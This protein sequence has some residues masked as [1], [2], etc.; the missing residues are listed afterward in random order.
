MKECDYIELYHY[1]KNCLEDP[2]RGL[3]INYSKFADNGINAERKNLEVLKYMQDS[4]E[5][6]KRIIDYILDFGVNQA[7]ND[8][9][10][11]DVANIKRF[12]TISTI[13]PLARCAYEK[14]LTMSDESVIKR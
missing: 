3:N 2:S 10:I 14:I 9:Y 6:E 5:N 1:I 13:I 4:Q 12:L 11:P 7:E 8:N